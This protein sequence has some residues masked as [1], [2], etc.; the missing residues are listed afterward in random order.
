MPLKPA[1]ILRTSPYRPVL[2]HSTLRRLLPGFTV[3]SLG[4]GMAVVAVSW[5]AIE[6]APAA[7]RALWVALAA[8]AYTLSGAVGAVLLGP[9]LRHRSPARLVA[10]DALLRAAAPGGVLP[11]RA[12]SRGPAPH[13]AALSSVGDAPRR[14]PRPPC[15]TR[16]RTPLP[17]PP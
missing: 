5:L 2:T 14:L 13:L 3:S 11:V 16:H 9:L 15:D 12:G 7:E 17:D 1:R 6:I 8:T 10:C 4:D